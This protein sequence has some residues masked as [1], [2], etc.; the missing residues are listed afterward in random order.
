[1]GKVGYKQNYFQNQ[2]QAEFILRINKPIVGIP[3]TDD[4]GAA[5]HLSQSKHYNRL[6]VNQRPP[7]TIARL[8]D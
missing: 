5:R 7:I 4:S 6:S 2:I 8:Y 1:M 3:N